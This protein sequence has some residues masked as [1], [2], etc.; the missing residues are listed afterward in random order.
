VSY[1]FII[2]SITNSG[3]FNVTIRTVDAIKE[4]GIDCDIYIDSEKK[5]YSSEELKKIQFVESNKSSI[6]KKYL[7][8]I[9][10]R[11]SI[12]FIKGLFVNKSSF[13]KYEKIFVC[14][15]TSK[16]KYYKL[17]GN[18]YY[19]IHNNK[20]FQLK[21]I[22]FLGQYLDLNLFKFIVKSKKLIAVSDSIKF[23]MIKHFKLKSDK[24]IT[25]YNPIEISRQYFSKKNYFIFAGRLAKQ[26]NVIFL[27]KAFKLFLLKSNKQFALVIFGNGPEFRSL[28]KYIKNNFFNNEVFINNFSANVLEKVESASATLLT[29]YYEGFPTVVIESLLLN[30][31]VISTPIGPVL[32]IKNKFKGV[33]CSDTFQVSDYANCLINFVNDNQLENIEFRD[34]FII[35]ELSYSNIALKYINC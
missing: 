18:V 31:P 35:K 19:I 6:V 21:E 15:L 16:F 26:K 17:I 24:I 12:V 30:T 34:D 32:E 4:Q 28:N 5:I 33:I 29:S 11:F 25:I 10:G 23:D 14:D 3:V 27:L 9:I 8:K 22:G 1:I 20:Y 7:K 2:E 13:L